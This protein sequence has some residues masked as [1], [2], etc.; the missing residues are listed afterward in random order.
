MAT[1]TK[2]YDWLGKHKTDRTPVGEF[3]RAMTKAPEFPQDLTTLD[4]LTAYLKSSGASSQVAAMARATW[5]A[6]ERGR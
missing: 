1:F 2:F 3:A 5:K 4:E 6:F